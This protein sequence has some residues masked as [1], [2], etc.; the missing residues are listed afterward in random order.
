[1]Q[2]VSGLKRRDVR[3]SRE[4]V[5]MLGSLHLYPVSIVDAALAG[6]ALHV[7]TANTLA[8]ARNCHERRTSSPESTCRAAPHTCTGLRA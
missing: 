3:H 4:H 6:L 8:A 2:H 5:R 7:Q 1:M